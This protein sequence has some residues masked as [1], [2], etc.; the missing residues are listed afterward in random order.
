MKKKIFIFKLV[1]Y[2]VTAILIYSCSPSGENNK[3]TIEYEKYVLDNGLEVVLHVDK[4]DP[5]VSTAIM[6]HVGS[7]REVPGKTG[8]AHLFEH[9]LFQ[10]SENIPQDEYFKKIQNAGGTLNGFTNNDITTYFEIVPKNA[11]E[12]VLWMESDR[13][14]YF[15]NTVTPSAFAIQQNVVQNEKRQMVDNR[16]Y[17]HTDYI[18]DKNL[19]PE[20]HPY[21]WQV[22]G[23][24]EDVNNATVDDVKEFYH[25]FYGPNNATLVIAGDFEVDSVK[26]LVSK[27]FAEIASH[28]QIDERE[29]MNVSL[30]G[31]KKIYHEDNFATVPELSMVW[32]AA[33]EF[34]KDA[35]ALSYLSEILTEGKSAPMYK[36]LVEEK[37]LTSRV[38]AFNDVR[39]LAG[40]FNIRVRA[41]E[42]HTLKEV[43]DAIHESF[44]LFEKEG[45]KQKDIEKVKAGLE[46]QFYNSINSVFYKSL[47]LAYYNT[48]LNNPGFIETDIENIKAITI[49]D[50][51]EVYN[52]F[53]KDKPC[54]VT[55]FVPKG[56]TDMIAENSQSA[57]IKEESVETALEVI[58]PQPGSEVEVQ[59]TPSAIDRSVQP[60]LG[61]DPAISLPEIWT[62]DLQNEIKVY[63]IEHNELPLV[64][65]EIMLKGGFLLDDTSKLG[66]AN[67]LTDLMMEG[68]KNKTPEELQDEIK[69]LG[70]DI[71]MYT[72]NEEIIF[73]ANTLSRN[74]SKT[75]KILE[76]M[77][78]EPRWDSLEFSLAK[79]RTMNG[80]IQSEA[81]PSF[82]ANLMMKKLLYGDGHIF[83]NDTRGK[84][85]DIEKITIQDLKDFYEKNF[86]PALA[87][88]QIA[89][90]VSKKQALKALQSLEAKWQKKDVEFPVYIVPEPIESSKIYFVDMPG[91]KQSV[92]N[93]GYLALSRSHPDFYP[94]YVMN[95]MLGGSFSSVLNMIL[96]EEKG[97]TYGARSGFGEQKEIAPFTASSSVRSNATRETVN[98]FKTEMEKYRQG[99]S[100]EDLEFTKN[101]LIR[102]NARRFET[103]GALNGMLRTVSKY[104]LSLDYIKEEENTVRS[105]TVERHKELAQKYIVPEKMVY[106]VVGDA[107]TQMN[108]LKSLGLGEPVLLK[109]QN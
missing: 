7:S 20:G 43:E 102:S 55:S 71:W 79:I 95:Y 89:G 62:A 66:V 88:V 38:S 99:I 40:S 64:S 15:I 50:V 8:F 106:L 68:T 29:A 63:G 108:S 60:L 49:E 34:S 73:S 57:D 4:S 53:I 70:A 6:Y 2:T 67:L 24:M 44:R 94:A 98:I 74:F 85:I 84:R 69:L 58:L 56:R 47:Q 21:S 96:R 42:G 46:R 81:N 19:F 39:E 23:E 87:S 27:Y 31:S 105:M 11:L 28:G 25:N 16:P 18:I 33:E 48:F 1:T 51:I 14:G 35:Y 17:G 54:V 32:P 83:A 91:S 36:V 107:Q 75:M 52:K 22:I 80:L 45:I 100:P 97:F 12:M 5:I 101:T 61:T 41:N 90:N 10:E 82:I 86:S 77:I 59:K 37:Q 76:E 109:Y 13:M 92:V 9:M 104:G 78:L 30:Y 72:T 65:V 93:I 3:L 103:L 26:A